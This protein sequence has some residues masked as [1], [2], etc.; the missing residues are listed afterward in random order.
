[1]ILVLVTSL[2]DRRVLILVVGLFERDLLKRVGR[3][4]DVRLIFGIVL[5]GKEGEIFEI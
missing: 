2:D 4:G 3:I 1:M 5:R